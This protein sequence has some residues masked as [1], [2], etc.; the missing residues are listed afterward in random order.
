MG[1][2][3]RNT[4]LFPIYTYK[5]VTVYFFG[6]FEYVSDSRGRVSIPPRY[7]SAFLKGVVIKESP[8][9]C[10]E[11]YTIEGFEEETSKRLGDHASNRKKEGRQVRRNFLAGA[12]E[13]DLDSQGRILI[14]PKFRE[15]LGNEKNIT[16]V[17]CGDY[18]E[19][20]PSSNWNNEK[21]INKK[22][23]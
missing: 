11:L 1:L 8:D 5:V 6:S 7:R 15:Y 22:D 10:L 23:E 9:T 17:G 20:W 16:I 19:I 13:I 21:L 2:N 4:L 12:F 18:I 3:G 14:P